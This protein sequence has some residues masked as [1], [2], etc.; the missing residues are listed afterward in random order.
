M[1]DMRHTV[2]YALSRVE[3][4][5]APPSYDAR[6]IAGRQRRAPNTPGVNHRPAVQKLPISGTTVFV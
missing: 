3:S 6:R 2:A 5:T 4:V 1:T